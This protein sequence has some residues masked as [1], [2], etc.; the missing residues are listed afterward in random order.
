MAFDLAEIRTRV[1][2]RAGLTTTDT[3][4]TEAVLTRII[5]A[6]LNTLALEADWPWLRV[7]TDL[8]TVAGQ[9]EYDPPA[10]WLRTIS[11][12]HSDTG[13][14][15]ARRHVKV[16]D[17]IPATSTGRP[18]QYAVDGG[19]ITL[20]YTPNGVLTLVHRYVKSEPTL[21]DADDTPLLPEAYGQGLIE[22][23]AAK[24]Y[25]M[26][27]DVER[28]Q[29]AKLDYAAWLKRARDNINQGREPLRVEVRPGSEF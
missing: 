9:A 7:K 26:K 2:D 25:T 6:G 29:E 27:K 1:R 3:L 16:L 19:K 15:L 17:R 13:E 12:T 23:C 8:T 28:T 21:V 14:P 22:W 4:V 11:L 18:F 10:L 5:N 20:R 24:A